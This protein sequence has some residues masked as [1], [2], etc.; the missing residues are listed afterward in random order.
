MPVTLREVALR[1]LIADD[2]ALARAVIEAIVKRDEELLRTI[3]AAP[4]L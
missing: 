2:D 3:P 1:V 4:G